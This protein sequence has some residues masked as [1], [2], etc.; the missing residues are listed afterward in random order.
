MPNVLYSDGAIAAVDAYSLAYRSY[1]SGVFS[2]TGIWSESQIV[3]H[4]FSEAEK[5]KF[6]IYSAVRQRI[7]PDP[8]LGA[9]PGNSLIIPWKTRY[10]F[11]TWEDRGDA[12]VVTDL[13]IR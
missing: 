9:A 11:V 6:E 1:F 13:E 7:S 10:L 4:Y 12:R 2:D 5:R 3:E 8:V